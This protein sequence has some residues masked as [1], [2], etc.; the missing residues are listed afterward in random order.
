VDTSTV[1]TYIVSYTASDL[2]GNEA[3]PVT[4]TVH[5]KDTLAPTI[6]LNGSTNITLECNVDSYTELGAVAEDL[7]DPNVNVVIGGDAVD[8]SSLGTYVVTYNAADASGN[9]AVEVTRTVVV[10]DTLQPEFSN[11]TN[12]T[13]EESAGCPD[14][15][16]IGM[17]LTLSDL[18]D[19]S[20]SVTT[21]FSYA[22][23]SSITRS[24]LPNPTE[25]F[26]L[27]ANT[28][29]MQATDASGNSTSAS[30]TVTILPRTKL[31]IEVSQ[32]EEGTTSLL[33][34][35]AVNVYN[36]STGSDADLADGNQG[37]GVPANSFDDVFLTVSPNYTGITDA[38]GE[39]TL[40]IMPGNYVAIAGID[41]NS[42]GIIDAS[43]R[44][45]GQQVFNLQCGDN[46][47]V[48]LKDHFYS[49]F[50]HHSISA[51]WKTEITGD[52]GAK[53]AQTD[54]F[55]YNNY[56]IYTNSQVTINGSM[57]ADSINLGWKTFVA[58]DVLYN[59]LQKAYQ[60]TIEGSEITP[61]ALPVADPSTAFP[62]IDPG[63]EDITV[64]V[65]TPT[66]LSPGTYGDVTLNN[67]WN[68]NRIA[69]LQLE[70]GL[71]EFN[72]L[73]IGYLGQVECLG[74][75][76]IRISDKLDLENKA[77]FGP[78]S[79]TNLVAEDLRLYVAGINGS[80]GTVSDYPPAVNLQDE[81]ECHA[82]ITAP[83]GTIHLGWKS[84][85]FGLLI[86]Q[87]VDIGSSAAVMID[88]PVED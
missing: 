65:N 71:Y 80:T 57:I 55:L 40:R 30:F 7:I 83:N 68:K 77:Y 29:S 27:G 15:T 28:V 82:V 85:M 87:W 20:P 8:T 36:I 78:T 53:D 47:S 63:M 22:D 16:N 18:C 70:P 24:G 75:C 35:T 84:E 13:A 10:Q 9:A 51:D 38:D 61:L 6:T 23:N 34:N 67:G 86:G 2:T 42:D 79:G 49:V 56:E 69:L 54:S 76:E 26:P 59:D 21:T 64:E 62:T 19:P 88:K 44:F 45:A 14:Y 17:T 66:V 60:A 46:Q 43:D 33:T 3:Q 39:L 32:I 48:L 12:I 5:V 11:V 58:N 1:G 74:P 25:S 4:R 81:I 52:V 31:N 72:S 50:A 41:I 37:N 73:D